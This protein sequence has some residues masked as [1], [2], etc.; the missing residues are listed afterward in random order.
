M[1]LII[2]SLYYLNDFQVYTNMEK[3]ENFLYLLDDTYIVFIH[4]NI[5]QQNKANPNNS[6]VSINNLEEFKPEYKGYNLKLLFYKKMLDFLSTEKYNIKEVKVIIPNDEYLRFN[7]EIILREMKINNYLLD[8]ENTLSV[9]EESRVIEFIDFSK[10]IYK[11]PNLLLSYKKLLF[12]QYRMDISYLIKRIFIQKTTLNIKNINLDTLLTAEYIS[13]YKN[14]NI[15]IENQKI[16]KIKNLS[17]VDYL[18]SDKINLEPNFSNIEHF[19]KLNFDKAKIELVKR[20]SFNK[21]NEWY[22][23]E[24]KK[25]FYIS[26]KKIDIENIKEIPKPS[27]QEIFNFLLKYNTINNVLWNLRNLYS[28]IEIN[29]NDI[30]LNEYFDLQRLFGFIK[31][32]PIKDKVEEFMLS[33][34]N[35]KEEKDFNDYI[36][37]NYKFEIINFINDLNMYIKLDQKPIGICPNCGKD[38]VYENE[39]TFFCIKCN[40][41]L[42]KNTLNVFKLK[43]LT[44]LDMK[45]IIENKFVSKKLLTKVSKKEQ[46]VKFYLNKLENNTYNLK[47]YYNHKK[48]TK[49]EIK[50]EELN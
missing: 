23:K 28:E 3:I 9:L 14:T 18:N 2:T 26:N 17:G 5:Y 34:E 15:Y 19:I 40:F 37:N 50:N 22:I 43:D 20:K 46:T 16:R 21:Y 30:I 42:F 24:Y 35:I 49:K 31:N 10:Y 6:N 12:F 8:Y 47:I 29:D 45:T 1:K 44:R 25:N 38:F 36:S 33:L 48:K 39:K 32:I 11:I 27:L 7:A 4:T 13:N 41:K